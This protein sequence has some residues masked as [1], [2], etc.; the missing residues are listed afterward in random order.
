MEE[1]RAN[2]Y[3]LVHGRSIITSVGLFPNFLVPYAKLASNW[4]MAMALAGIGMQ[5][6]FQQF[7]EAGA[8][9][10]LTGLATWF[11]VDCH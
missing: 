8:K 6:S 11:M 2:V 5:V 9:P 10:I 4:L 1:Y 7:K 3:H